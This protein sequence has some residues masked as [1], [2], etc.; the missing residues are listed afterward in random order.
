[1]DFITEE[2]RETPVA[3]EA[4]VLV[5]GGGVAG[6]AAAICAARNNAQVLLVERY[7]F[8]GGLCTGGLVL[9]MP[10]LNNGLNSEIRQRLED[11]GVYKK[12][13]DK[14]DP[15]FEE[16]DVSAIDAEVLKYEFIPFI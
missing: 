12:C 15:R 7:G 16:T 4:D 8:L 1:M 9:A 11:A 6:V 2:T 3:A 10:R 13:V 14:G 5:C